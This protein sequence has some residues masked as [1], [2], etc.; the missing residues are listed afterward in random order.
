VA[1][2]PATVVVGRDVRRALGRASRH[3]PW[4]ST[5]L[6]RAIA[7]RIMLR[8]RQCPGTVFVGVERRQGSDHAFHA[9]LLAGGVPITGV[10]EARRF[11]VVATF[12]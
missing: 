10:S 7:G 11:T 4:H 8:R 2:A 9:W 12:R 3:L 5:C 1:V 6:M